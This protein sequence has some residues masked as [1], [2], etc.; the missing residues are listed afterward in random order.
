[1]NPW[2][3]V[4]EVQ[5]IKDHVHTSSFIWI[6]ILFDEAFKYGDGTDSWGYTGPYADHSV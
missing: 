6:N 1:M 3:S 5:Y 4:D 2:T